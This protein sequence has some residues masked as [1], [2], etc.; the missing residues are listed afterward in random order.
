MAH[1]Y[2]FSIVRGGGSEDDLKEI[3]R[4]AKDGWEAF[5][6]VMYTFERHWFFRRPIVKQE[7]KP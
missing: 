3:S 2:T 5:T 4:L 6:C 7:S 1:E